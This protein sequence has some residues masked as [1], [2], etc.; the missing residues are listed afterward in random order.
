MNQQNTAT[1]LLIFIHPVQQQA[2]D[3]SHKNNRMW[4]PPTLNQVL[5]DQAGPRQLQ[6]PLVHVP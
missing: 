6:R 5:A 1:L 3:E 2:N 4:E